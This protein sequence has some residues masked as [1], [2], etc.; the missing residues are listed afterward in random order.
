MPK[1]L[2]NA[3]VVAFAALW[4]AG[5]GNIPQH[6]V[7]NM[8]AGQL[9]TIIGPATRYEVHASGHADSIMRGRVKQITVHGDNVQLSHYVTVVS[10]DV[11]ATDICVSPRSHEVN[12]LGPVRFSVTLDQKAIDRYMLLTSDEVND[13]PPQMRVTLRKRDIG[14]HYVDRIWRGRIPVTVLG[15]LALSAKGSNQLDFVPSRGSVSKLKVP[16]SIVRFVV[17]RMNPV[18]DLTQTT[19]P[20]TVTG[21]SEKDDQ[22]TVTGLVTMTVPNINKAIERSHG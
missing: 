14:V 5:C 11:V 12:S 6:K 15:K 7:E 4:L 2:F 17:N 18:L 8:I 21:V 9:P 10:F 13:R 1:R 20:I 22:L 19:V 3:I 16:E